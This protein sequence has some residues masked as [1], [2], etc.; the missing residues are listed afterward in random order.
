[1]APCRWSRDRPRHRDAHHEEPQVAAHLLA[2]VAHGTYVE[3]LHP[4]PD[5]LFWNLIANRP[6]IRGGRCAVP[7]SVGLGLVLDVDYI[8]R[9][10]SDR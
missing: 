2:A 7:E 6:P 9:Y 8:A 10:R 5:P 1:M 4:D 3:C